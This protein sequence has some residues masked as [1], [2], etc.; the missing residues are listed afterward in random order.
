MERNSIKKALPRMIKIMVLVLL[1]LIF[2]VNIWL[3]LHIHHQSQKESSYETF[4][5]LK[6]LIAMNKRDLD[7]AKQDFSKKCIQSAE[8][9]AYFVEYFPEITED[10]EHTRQLAEKLAV[11]ELHF[12]TSEG[13]LYF[14]THPEYYGYTFYSG[15]QIGF[16]LP[17]LKD[18][19]LKLC[20]GIEKNTAEGK[21][22]Q[23]AAVWLKD[24]SG[25]VQI[26][27]NPEKLVRELQ[28][29]SLAKL[30]ASMPLDFRG[31]LHVIEKSTNRIVAS[32]EPALIGINM[33]EEVEKGRDIRKSD[34]Y[35]YIFHGRKYCVYRQDYGNYTLLRT[36]L[37]SYPLKE[38]VMSTILV[39]AYISVAAI[40]AIGL[41]AWYVNRKISS[42]LMKIVEELKK[43]EQG[44]LNSISLTTEITEFDEL[45][46]YINELM[47]SIRINWNKM[48]Y[49]LD[50]SGV[51]LGIYEYNVF[52]KRTFMNDR[53]LNI[54]GMDNLHH[55]SEETINHL[56]KKR[57]EETEKRTGKQEKYICEYD[58]NGQTVYLRIEK[59]IDDQSIT[60]Y[61][62]DVSLWLGEIH[63][64]REQSS[65]DTLT[66]LYN[67]RGF[68][69][70][71]DEI[72]ENPDKIG[73]GLVLMLDADGL[74]KINDV[75]GHYM[76]DGYLKEIAYAMRE[77]M[78]ENSV[79]ARFGGDEFAVL[80][81]GYPSCEAVK[82]RI[83]ELK[84]KRGQVFMPDNP[85]IEETLEFSLGYAFYPMD[86][87]DYHALL[88]IADE[89]MYQE[90][91]ER[92]RGKTDSRT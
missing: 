74:K 31:A 12:F 71:A 23:Y 61:V 81:Y 63:M 49:V 28:D 2:P 37:S 83:E 91:R 16:F 53:L 59:I 84:L 27:M 43:V 51:P 62:A 54:L 64:L 46:F 33:D 66:S 29:R 26:G 24:G 88:H 41:I 76:G 69:E 89:K 52:Y 25:I 78:G 86:G 92:K 36:Y 22:M 75:Y 73:Y 42:N 60:Y 14:G 44:N 56:V 13:E 67:R 10:L 21:E 35:H 18:H 20:Q 38:S 80:L 70:K 79:C 17:M 90:K 57:L 82:E 55:E 9:A 34:E 6:Q 85:D 58:K 15:E 47:K 11:D 32:T 77:A 50:K 3:Q 87:N 39:L 65:T 72:F 4:G 40:I 8:M 45:I 5:Q 19:N 48:S 7:Q 1:V 30:I 68:N